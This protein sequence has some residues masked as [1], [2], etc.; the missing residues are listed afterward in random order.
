M[1]AELFVFDD[2]RFGTGAADAGEKFA[3]QV[4]RN[5]DDAIVRRRIGI[6]TGIGMDVIA[7]EK[8][9]APVR[10]FVRRAVDGDGV[11]PAADDEHL[12]V[13][14]KVRRKFMGKVT[15]GF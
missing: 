2:G 6:Q 7:H 4:G 3:E 12:H 15:G 11:V 14:V 8:S 1:P 13:H 5:D 9:D 10:H